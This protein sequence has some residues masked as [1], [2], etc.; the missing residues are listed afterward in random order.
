VQIVIGVND[1]KIENYLFIT[2]KPFNQLVKKT[3]KTPALSPSK[4]E[5]LK[6]KNER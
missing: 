1:M 2:P 6:T 3:Q 5:Q 4:N